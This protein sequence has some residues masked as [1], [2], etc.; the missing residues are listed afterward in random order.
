PV[1]RTQLCE[2]LWDLPNDPRGELRWCLSK[3]RSL[4]GGPGRPRVET[5][6]DTIRL[7]LSDCRIDA[8]VVAAAVQ[9]GVERLGPDQL[10]AL[11][12][13]FSGDFLEGLEVGRSPG[14]NNWLVAQR[15]RFRAC[16]AAILEHLVKDA[17]DDDAFEHLD[18]WLD[19]APFDQRV[20][21]I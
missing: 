12:G 7:D 19:L 16:H 18:R 14:F 20:H 3:I 6:D 15:R 8:A 13:L 21:K 17:S 11:A 9:R 10:R 1:P 4:V 2:L 5:N